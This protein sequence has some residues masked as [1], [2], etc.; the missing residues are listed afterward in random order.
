M[1]GTPCEAALK[2]FDEP[3]PYLPEGS[4]HSLVKRK[5]EQIS[6]SIRSAKGPDPSLLVGSQAHS[7]KAISILFFAASFMLLVGIVISV[8]H[9]WKPK[10]LSSLMSLLSL[11]TDEDS[12]VSEKGYAGTTYDRQH[13]QISRPVETTSLRA[14]AIDNNATSGLRLRNQTSP[15]LRRTDIWTAA[16]AGDPGVIQEFLESHDCPDI[17]RVHEKLGTP[18][19]AAAQSGKSE[20][21]SRILKWKPNANIEGGRPEPTPSGSVFRQSQNR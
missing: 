17:N 9:R 13:D 16:L 12:L 6:E 21:A 2:A 3:P 5:R 11:R 20:A 4:S 19:Q 10:I 1:T 15:Q 8:V 18:L 14:S 7:Q